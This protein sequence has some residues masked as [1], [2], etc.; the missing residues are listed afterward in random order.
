MKERLT[1]VRIGERERLNR[2]LERVL[3]GCP[4]E[5]TCLGTEGDF[6][7]RPGARLLFALGMGEQGER[8]VCRLRK[9]LG[10]ERPDLTGCIGAFL[11]DGEGESGLK[12]TARSLIYGLNQRGCR[13]VGKSLVEATGALQNFRVLARVGGTDLEDAYQNAARELTERLTGWNWRGTKRPRV[14][15]L[16]AS[17]R[18]TSNTLYLGGRIAE[19]LRAKAEVSEIALANGTVTDCRGC[20]HRACKHYG[21]QRT[22]YY[23]GVVVEEVYPAVL[24]SDALL[25]IC[26][27]Y[28]DALSANLTACINRLT[29]LSKTN[30]FF[31][32][33]I[34]CVVVSGY[35]DG[36]L[37]AKQLLGALN[38]NKTFHLPPDFSLLAT[39]NDRGELA[40]MPGTEPMAGEF[41]HRMLL[42]L[43][44]A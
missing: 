38:L 19:T 34:Y 26:P 31:D 22:C 23:G 6:P 16:H 24:A 37:V 1:L 11:L 4:T 5:E 2:L 28:N 3:Q 36:D 14:T 18:E 9:F 21:E 44:S 35:G 17:D 10:T 25:F 15:L 40:R 33:R 29:A 8:D 27:N 30:G 12:E 39:A 13:F 42:E 32:T 20:S 41:A 43:V 7:F